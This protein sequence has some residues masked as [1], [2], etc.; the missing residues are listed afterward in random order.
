MFSCLYNDCARE[1]FIYYC[2]IIEWL[3]KDLDSYYDMLNVSKIYR[4]QIKMIIDY[5]ERDSRLTETWCWF[6][7]DLCWVV[8]VSSAPGPQMCWGIVFVEAKAPASGLAPWSLQ[9]A[10]FAER[11]TEEIG[12]TGCP[13]KHHITLEDS[14]A[15]KWKRECL[16]P[17]VTVA[18]SCIIYEF[19]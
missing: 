18:N 1:A 5:Y 16:C 14:T 6:P 12:R 17:P 10:V 9:R 13:L 19:W 11:V 3:Q 2:S 8:S 15:E 4:T 7:W